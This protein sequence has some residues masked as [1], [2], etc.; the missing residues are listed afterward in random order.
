[1]TPRDREIVRWIGRL[2]MATAVQVAERFG[3]GRA[4]SYARLNGIV[5]L[6][7]LDHARIF[8]ASPGV[9]LTTRAGL[10]C[11]DLELPPSRVDLRTYDH[12]LELS[13]LVGELEREFGAGW[14]STEREMRAADTPGGSAPAERPRFAVPLA[15]GR[16]QLQ[17]TPVGHPR[18]HFPDCAVRLGDDRARSQVV[19]VELERTAKGRARLRRIL[20]GYIASLHVGA[21]RYYVTSGRVRDLVATEVELLRAVDFIEIR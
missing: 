2:R 10:A 14:I 8:H 11:V 12:D 16:G 18:L 21:V 3:L 7:L 13:T 15:G 4:V 20:S 6:G 19:A 1:M 5:R 17:L 9:Y